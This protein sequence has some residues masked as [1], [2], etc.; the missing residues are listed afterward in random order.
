VEHIVQ[1]KHERS[2][3]GSKATIRWCFPY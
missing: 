1:Q 2:A 3:S